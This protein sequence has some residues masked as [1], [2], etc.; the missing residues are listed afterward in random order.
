M[1]IDLKKFVATER[2]FWSELESRLDR[3]E[4]EIQGALSLEDLQRFHYLYERAAADLA[5]VATFASEPDLHRYL[6]NLVARAYSEIHETRARQHRWA[7]LAW[8]LQTLPQT[9]RRHLGAF[10]LSTAITLAGM[11]FGGVS[12]TFDE[13]AKTAIVP[14]Q[15]AHLMQDPAER[16]AREESM[17]Q[18]PGADGMTTFSAQLMT[19]NIGVSLKALALGITYGLGTVILLFYN[20]IIVGLVAADYIA[21]GQTTFLLG[22]L[23]PHGSIEIPSIL[24]GGQT[25]LILAGALIGWGS[26]ETLGMR[27][28][29]ISGDLVTL[30][31]G[32]AVLLVW[33]GIVEA[34]FSQFHE[35][36]LPYAVKIAFGTV[37][38]ALLAVFLSRCGK[39]SEA[40]T[41]VG[42]SGMAAWRRLEEPLENEFAKRPYP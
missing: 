8:F 33:A 35:P 38:L 34:F 36:V 1:I 42:D 10:W 2:P 13:E 6:E 14:A 11:L 7:P 37:E 18:G 16:V 39:S 30:I 26:R 28:R 41:G 22:W 20:G 3:V 17:R 12:V 23:L 29:A 19:N 32:V 21:A 24:M 15:F 40:E 31:G 5:K 4:T 25:G 27:L 9:F